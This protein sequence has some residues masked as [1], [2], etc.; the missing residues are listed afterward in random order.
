MPVIG[1]YV[2]EM[3]SPFY[4]LWAI[5]ILYKHRKKVPDFFSY[6]KDVNLNWLFYF[7]HGF[8]AYLVFGLLTSLI[9]EIFAYEMVLNVYSYTGII[10]VAYVFGIGY[11]GYGQKS[12]FV[13][14]D[15]EITPQFAIASE[16]KP[17]TKTIKV[18]ALKK[19]KRENETKKS[20]YQ[21]SGLKDS[22]SHHLIL[23]LNEF[24]ETEK[25]FL[26]CELNLKML[27][28]AIDVSPHNISQ[29]L[30]EHHGQNFF[31]YINKYRVDEVKRLLEKN[32]SESY[33]L[34]SLAFEAGFNSKSTF[35]TAFK[36][37]TQL[38]PAQYRK[39]IAIE[40]MS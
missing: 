1:R 27:A 3:N 12:I 20:R 8:A 24:M 31:D 22:E 35:Y 36:K 4:Y 19:E 32:G 11:F 25:P 9:Y 2:F 33:T 5:Y 39:Q 15:A 13:D 14:F 17:L 30:N 34:L 16:I 37:H 23:K 6:T 40:A 26:D 7:T 18:E 38:T 10:L 29:V 28:E 21:K